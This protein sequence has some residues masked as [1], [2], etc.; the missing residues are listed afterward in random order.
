MLIAAAGWA[1]RDCELGP[2]DI[3]M[4][5]FG[6]HAQPIK[7]WL[8]RSLSCIDA[9]GVLSSLAAINKLLPS[10]LLLRLSQHMLMAQNWALACPASAHAAIYA[11]MLVACY[12]AILISCIHTRNNHRLSETQELPEVSEKGLRSRSSALVANFMVF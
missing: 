3:V 2:D 10:N 5:A 8:E 9:A 4:H 12:K 1:I 7:L 11:R 6:M